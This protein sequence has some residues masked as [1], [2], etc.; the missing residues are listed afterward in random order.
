MREVKQTVNSMD[1][2]ANEK[3]VAENAEKVTL[4]KHTPEQ[5]PSTFVEDTNSSQFYKGMSN[6]IDRIQGSDAPMQDVMKEAIQNGELSQQQ[7]MMI[8]ARYGELVREGSSPEGALAKMEKD[9]IHMTKYHEAQEYAREQSS[10]AL[11]RINEKTSTNVDKTT[12][13][14]ETQDVTKQAVVQ[15][16]LAQQIQH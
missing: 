16:K 13:V 6:I 1:N 14:V 5:T 9:Y 8:N 2:N 11:N 7:V 4:T 12:V 15:A 3:I 10:K